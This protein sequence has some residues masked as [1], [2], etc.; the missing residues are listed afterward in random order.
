MNQII[1]PRYVKCVPC[2]RRHQAMATGPVQASGAI[3][4]GGV[5]VPGSGSGHHHPDTFTVT[6]RDTFTLSWQAAWP[7]D[8]NCDNEE[9]CYVMYY[10]KP[11][12]S[13]QL[14]WK[15]L[16]NYVKA[17]LW[18]IFPN[19]YP[20]NKFNSRNNDPSWRSLLGNIRTLTTLFGIL[21][22]H[23][24]SLSGLEYINLT[25]TTAKIIFLFLTNWETINNQS[26][27]SFM[28][29]YL[30]DNVFLMTLNNIYYR[31][32]IG[33]DSNGFYLSGNQNSTNQIRSVTDWDWW[34]CP[35]HDVVPI[36]CWGWIINPDNGT[37]TKHPS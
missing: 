13:W 18:D 27:C 3:Q 21:S 9:T 1:S 10:S 23:P 12:N 19:I 33:L 14:E 30:D 5:S 8:I 36:W 37:Y 34:L 17:F 35:S 24:R 20:F 6:R 15:G 22:L 29:L 32:A 11:S 16:W 28:D 31:A 4:R 26:S 25:S 2:C 7:R